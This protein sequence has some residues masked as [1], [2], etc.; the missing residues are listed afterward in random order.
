MPLISVII[1]VYN[2]EKTIRET[3]ESALN[4]TFYDL[5]IIVIDDGSKDSSWNIVSSIKDP[6]I[7]LF[8]YKNSGV[9]V[10]R[11]RGLAHASGEF[12]AF[13]DADDLW[14]PDKLEAQFKALQTNPE[15]AVAYSWVNYITENGEFFRL[16]SHTS[17]NGSIYEK[18]LVENILENG[19]NPLIRKQALTEV[20]DFNQA[21]SPA[22]D[23]DMWLRLAVRYHYVAVSR[24][25]ILYRMSP[26]STS[27]NILKM[28]AACLR[29]L[30]EAFND[31]PESLQQMKRNS[32]AC[33]YKYL[34]L[35]ALEAPLARKNGIIAIRYFWQVIKNN[36]S[37][38]LEWTTMSKVLCKIFGVIILPCTQYLWLKNTFKKMFLRQK[39]PLNFTN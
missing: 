30:E 16:G 27:S 32:F 37:V 17:I 6:R 35:K 9:A 4:Q 21:L 14:T 38:L 8:K 34:G 2:G 33:L 29:L 13:L 10:S 7:K 19:S 31:A 22:D 25:Q 36:P 15:A 12:I 5:E 20:G 18:L 24:P 28:E 3:I 1:P 23:W 39:Y 26:H 11:N